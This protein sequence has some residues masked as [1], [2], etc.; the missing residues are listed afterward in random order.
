[1][2]PAIRDGDFALWESH[3]IIRYLC[4]RYGAG[5]LWPEDAA[6]ARRGRSVDGMVREPAPSRR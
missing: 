2:I 6:D 3:A 5:G 4:T 1:M